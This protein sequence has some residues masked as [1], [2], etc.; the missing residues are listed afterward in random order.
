MWREDAVHRPLVDSEEEE[1][2]SA[3]DEADRF[4]AQYNFRHEEEGASVVKTYSRD[5]ES[6]RKKTSSR[7]E[8][9]ER[10]KERKYQK[11]VS[12]MLG[13]GGCAFVCVCLVSL[14]ACV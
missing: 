12:M 5:V 9:R 4:E 11:K 3:A 1:D 10:R 2:A 6:V 14:L 8:A 7:A 13:G